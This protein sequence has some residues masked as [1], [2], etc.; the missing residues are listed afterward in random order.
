[1]KIK[2]INC[3]ICGKQLINL[4]WHLEEGKF[5]YWCD[6]CHIEIT[7]KEDEEDD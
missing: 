1:M 3:P 2:Y 7:V 4:E 5:N 6:D